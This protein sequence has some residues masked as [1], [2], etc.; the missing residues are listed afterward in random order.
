[1]ENFNHIDEI[2]GTPLDE[3]T[4]GKVD[5]KIPGWQ[6]AL[7]ISAIAAVGIGIYYCLEYHK[8]KVDEK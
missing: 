5:G 3:I 4:Q 1:M 7:G 2:F 8:N 6:I